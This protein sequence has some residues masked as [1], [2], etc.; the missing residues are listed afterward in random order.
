MT[1]QWKKELPF[2][3]GGPFKDDYVFSQLHLH[4]GIND[5]EGSEHTID[6][7]YLPGEMHLIFFKSSYLKHESALKENDGIA[8]LVYLI[9]VFKFYSKKQ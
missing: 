5:M 3:T 2:L 1:G 9:N 6:G 7:A 4:W 8:I